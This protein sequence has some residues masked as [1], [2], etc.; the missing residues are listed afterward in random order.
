MNWQ[1]CFP[2]NAP[3][4]LIFNFM[5]IAMVCLILQINFLI[6]FSKE[7]IVDMLS[8][9]RNNILVRTY[10]MG[11]PS[12]RILP[13]RHISLVCLSTFTIGKEC[14]HPP[15]LLMISLILV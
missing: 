13:K 8:V 10:L 11:G 12:E 4:H 5:Y 2:L 15:D 3:I 9:E 6:S 1:S 7:V 14:R